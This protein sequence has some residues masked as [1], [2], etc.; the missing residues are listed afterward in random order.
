MHSLTYSVCPL[1]LK[2]I[3]FV[4]EACTSA[5][6]TCF[7]W[8]HREKIY[9]V[10]NWHCF[11]GI[12]ADTNTLMQL[13]PNRITIGL[14]EEVAPEIYQRKFHDV[15]LYDDDGMPRWLEHNLGR[16]VDCAAL[17]LVNFAAL[18]V[19]SRPLNLLDEF[20]PMTPEVA[21]DVFIVGYPEGLSGNGKTPIWKRGSIASEPE[22]N[23]GGKPLFLVD[24]ATR[25]GMSGSPAI[26]RHAGIFNPSGKL[27]N[28]S[29]FGAEDIVGIYSGRVAADEMGMQIGRVWK[30]QVIEEIL[31]AQ[32]RGID[33]NHAQ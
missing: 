16:E 15:E 11:T 20:T 27:D 24:S 8:S 33:P 5:S 14:L 6:A 30:K 1:E 29:V 2:R 21:M 32:I 28:Q 31:G 25:K 26:L 23:H 12:D 4:G 13:V 19:S 18:N 9:I 22:L 17:E 10:S 3:N 7:L